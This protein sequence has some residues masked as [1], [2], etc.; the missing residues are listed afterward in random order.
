MYAGRTHLKSFEN[1]LKAVP[2]KASKKLEESIRNELEESIRNELEESIRNELE[3][4]IRNEL[5]ESI[6]NELEES[7]RNELEE[8][9]NRGQTYS[10]QVTYCLKRMFIFP[11]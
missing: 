3:E 9:S 8:S 7:I 1:K 2:L 5:E 4:S 10:K 11:V 6:R